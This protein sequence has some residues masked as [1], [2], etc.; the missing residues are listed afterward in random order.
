[1]NAAAAL[2]EN[3]TFCVP[4]VLGIFFAG[5]L[6]NTTTIIFFECEAF[7]LLV[8]LLFCGK[9]FV[10]LRPEFEKRHQF[11][12]GKANGFCKGRRCLKKLKVNKFKMMDNRL[13]FMPTKIILDL[14]GPAP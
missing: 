10:F 7:C 2:T 1:M 5:F 12:Q 3:N 11:T 14:I 9:N 13:V 8:L 6:S 4:C